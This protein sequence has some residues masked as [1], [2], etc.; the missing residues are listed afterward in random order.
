MQGDLHA[1]AIQRRLGSCGTFFA[2]L[3]IGEQQRRVAMRLPEAAQQRERRLRQRNEAILVAFGIADMHT[4]ARRI[5]IPQL[6]SQSFAQAQS[7]AIQREEEHPVTE[8][9]RGGEYP[10]GLLD[11]DHVRQALASR[12][13]DQAPEM[14]KA[15]ARRA[16]SKTSTRTDQV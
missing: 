1:A 3:A 16:G 14:P 10:T 15:C 6:Q 12:G 8:H 2:G 11:C 13:L 5:D 4:V 9:A 7:Q